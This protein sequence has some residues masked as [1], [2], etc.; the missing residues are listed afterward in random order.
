MSN[1]QVSSVVPPV[2]T[3]ISLSWNL[4]APFMTKI[5][6]GR[7]VQ[8]RENMSLRRKFVAKK[9]INKYHEFYIKIFDLEVMKQNKIQSEFPS[10][11]I[12]V[13][14]IFSRVLSLSSKTFNKKVSRLTFGLKAKDS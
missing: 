1:R 3:L 2:T 8:K 7:R 9:L 13:K 14:R 11:K 10:P 6:T 4:Q 12:K 5:S